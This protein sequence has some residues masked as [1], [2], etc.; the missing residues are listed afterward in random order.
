MKLVRVGGHFKKIKTDEFSD[1]KQERDVLHKTISVDPDSGLL[2]PKERKFKTK[3]K[4]KPKTEVSSF[5]EKIIPESVINEHT[6]NIDE[7]VKDIYQYTDTKVQ[8]VQAN[9]LRC[10]N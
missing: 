9:L 5:V 7:Q 3:I 8:E 4:E 10:Y 6:K 1:S 2:K